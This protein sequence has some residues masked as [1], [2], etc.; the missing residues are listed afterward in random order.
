MTAEIAVGGAWLVF[1]ASHIGLA[2]VRRPLIA[3]IGEV[4]F[5]VV[6]SALAQVLFTV[7]V[8]TYA[9]RRFEGAPG[10]ALG[11]VAVVRSIL[12]TCIV[13][14]VALMTAAFA[15]AQYFRSPQSLL[16]AKARE[17][18]GLERITRH[19]F[20]AGLV[21]AFGAHAL[22]ATRLAGT[23]FFSGFV[24]L[25]IGGA[26]HQG[27]KLV[28]EKGPDYAR[29]L[30][31]TSAVPF[32]A[33]LRGKQRFA[34]REMPWLFVALGCGAA[35]LLRRVH[36]DLF[37]AD[38]VWLAGFIVVATTFF[39]GEAIVRSRRHARRAKTS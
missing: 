9:T 21:I 1:V 6:Y 28:A 17:A 15:P 19:P 34:W 27:R 29:F 23:I 13:L 14:G 20:F 36:A 25:A 33:I 2:H 24:I 16:R 11:E 10:L 30:E 38:G 39:V 26:M 8:V 5:L 32:A 22:L 35:W 7:L 31:T 4:P 3:K 12:V 37:A 18:Y